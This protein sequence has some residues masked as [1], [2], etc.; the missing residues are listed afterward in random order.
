MAV[1][2]FH[3]VS[4]DPEIAEDILTIFSFFARAENVVYLDDYRD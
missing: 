1:A 3:L 4:I 2:I